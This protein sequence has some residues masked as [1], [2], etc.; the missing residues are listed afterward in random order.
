MVAIREGFFTC[1]QWKIGILGL[2]LAGSFLALVAK[3]SL[4]VN[5]NKGNP[6]SHLTE[7]GVVIWIFSLRQI[8]SDESSDIHSNECTHVI[9]IPWTVMTGM[10][11]ILSSLPA[12]PQRE[13]PKTAAV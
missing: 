3:D 12:L 10:A 1:W 13:A 8:F 9:V 2:T 4:G 5:Q 7:M 6:S 11:C